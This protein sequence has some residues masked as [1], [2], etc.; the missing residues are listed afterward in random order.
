MSGRRA[1]ALRVLA[2]LEERSKY[3]YVPSSARAAIYTGLG[4]K[5]QAFAWLDRAYAERDHFWRELKTLSLFDSLRSDP[6]FTRLLNQLH[7][8]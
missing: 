6:Q 2:E 8:E 4:D 1:E 3:E 7:L 5:E